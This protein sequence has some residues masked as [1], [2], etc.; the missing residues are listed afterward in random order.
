MREPLI[1]TRKRE[2]EV[3]AD[4]RTVVIRPSSPLFF[5]LMKVLVAK[6]S[7]TRIEKNADY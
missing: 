7:P 1:A 5:G 2:S 3:V 6:L 4:Q